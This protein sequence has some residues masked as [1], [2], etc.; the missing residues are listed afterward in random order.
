MFAS[1]VFNLRFHLCYQPDFSKALSDYLE[2]ELDIGTEPFQKK[3]SLTYEVEYKPTVHSTC[4][5]LASLSTRDACPLS[6]GF[7]RAALTWFA[8]DQL[9]PHR[10]QC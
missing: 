7:W 9:S 6:R 8:E 5:S 2:K 4:A 3:K 1:R 10:A